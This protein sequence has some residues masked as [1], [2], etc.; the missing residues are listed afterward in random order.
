M[1]VRRLQRSRTPGSARAVMPSSTESAPDAIAGHGMHH[2]ARV[3]QLAA[4]AQRRR[5]PLVVDRGPAVSRLSSGTSNSEPTAWAHGEY[6][7]AVIAHLV[8]RR[9]GKRDA[10][11]EPTQ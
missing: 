11:Q 1:P 8:E 9:S 6:C 4:I 5:S 3:P 10:A 7:P 2:I